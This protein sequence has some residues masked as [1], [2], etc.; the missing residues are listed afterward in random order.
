ML[1]LDGAGRTGGT[2]AVIRGRPHGLVVSLDSFIPEE[3]PKR[4]LDPEFIEMSTLFTAK[5]P[6]ETEELRR[7]LI[8]VGTEA[9]EAGFTAEDVLEAAPGGRKAY[10]RNLIGSVIGNL[11][12][13]KHALILVDGRVPSE[14]PAAKKR[15]I[16]RYRLNPDAIRVTGD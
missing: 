16:N 14:H 13:R 8:R 11:R 1:L 7:A 12:G 4:S 3:Q 9:G 6:R 15:W 5:Y 2:G 10:P